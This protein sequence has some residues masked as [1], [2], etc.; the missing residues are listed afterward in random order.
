VADE[1][2]IGERFQ[3]LAG[4]L[5]E[6]GLRV[7]AAAEATSLGWGGTAAVARATGIAASTI[8]RGRAELASGESPGA[9]R[10]RR[11]GA[12]RKPLTETDL[13]LLEDLERLVDGE[14]RGDPERPLRWTA[15]SLRNL[16][17]ELRA[18]GHLISDRSVAP[19]LRQLGYSLQANAKTREGARHPDRD[20]Q[21][22]H[23]NTTIA[24][25]LDAGEPAIS[26]DTKKK[27]L[28][29]DF[30]NAGRE[31]RRKGQPEQVR[32]HDFRDAD[33]ELG[34]AAPYGVY[35]IADDVGWVNV[36]IDNDTAQFAVE[37]IRGW[38][39]QLGSSR[40]PNATCLTITADCG[41]S[42]RQ[43]HPALEDRTASTGRRNTSCDPRLPLPARH[44]Q[45]EQDRAP[46]VQLHQHQ[47][48]RQTARLPPD[49][50]QPNRRH[51]DPH[52]PDRPRPPRRTH[53]RQRNQNHRR[54]A[55][56]RQ[57]HRRPLP[58]RMELHHQPARQMMRR[59][60]VSVR[61]PR[62]VTT[63]V[64]WS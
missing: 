40:Y 25:A 34:K 14:S 6:R 16:A 10:V 21:F 39:Q 54:R 20:A 35:D 26:V 1:A 11:P 13:T 4:E 57:P 31:L 12:G 37:S 29:G 50:H 30:K 36:G 38:W 55:C 58:P 59:P 41:G 64:F 45:M 23:I 43:P 5:D 28:V 47:L 62:R 17:A 7:W 3:L 52:R 24:A 8:R 56:R 19:L 44:Q 42:K 27:E 22:R 2:A 46:P 9:G 63:R 51:H 32:T 33:P 61:Q 49:D 48:A 15:K 60:L 18:Q 53:L